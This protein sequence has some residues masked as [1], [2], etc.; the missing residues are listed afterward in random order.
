MEARGSSLTRAPSGNRLY[1]S[2]YQETYSSPFEGY[3]EVKHGRCESSRKAQYEWMTIP[4][5][6]RGQ[7]KKEMVSSKDVQMV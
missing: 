2:L 3:S 7:G 4:E 6:P 1:D 5:G